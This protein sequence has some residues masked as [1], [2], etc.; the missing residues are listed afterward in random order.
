M[1]PLWLGDPV[2]NPDG[3]CVIGNSLTSCLASKR[4]DYLSVGTV[5]FGSDSPNASLSFAMEAGR[6]YF[7]YLSSTAFARF[8]AHLDARNTILTRWNDQTGLTAAP[9]MTVPEPGTLA[10]L[11]LGLAGLGWSRSR[12]PV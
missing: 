10:L 12:R 2:S 4:A 3:P 6:S 7:T 9:G 5:Q 8:G 11:G 1:D